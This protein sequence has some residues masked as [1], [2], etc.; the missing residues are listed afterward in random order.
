M[1]GGF[2]GGG[3]DGVLPGL[4]GFPLALFCLGCILVNHNSVRCFFAFLVQLPILPDICM[5]CPSSH[6]SDPAC[7]PVVSVP[8]IVFISSPIVD[9]QPE[10]PP[11]VFQ[12]AAFE[13]DCVQNG[14]LFRVV[15][16]EIPDNKQGDQPAGDQLGNWWE[17]LQQRRDSTGRRGQQQEPNHRVPEPMPVGES[18]VVPDKSCY[19]QNFL[20]DGV[21]RLIG[22]HGI[23][24]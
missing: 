9:V 8:S 23:H 7:Q 5:P 15:R 24:R 16:N 1:G 6:V 12:R 21:S 22:N 3:G 14:G 17:Q 13:A 19:V 20:P 10:F 4:A 11:F 2:G 18:L